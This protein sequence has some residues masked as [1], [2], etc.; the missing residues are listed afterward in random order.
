QQIGTDDKVSSASSC[1]DHR[2]FHQST[3]TP[4]TRSDSGR[5]EYPPHKQHSHRT[6]S[7]Q[8]PSIQRIGEEVDAGELLG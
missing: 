7:L 6:A 3:Q 4:G 8:K 5:T 1:Y 2:W